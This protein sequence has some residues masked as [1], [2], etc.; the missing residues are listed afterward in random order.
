[1]KTE[2]CL[3]EDD[4]SMGESLVERMQLEGYDVTLF[5]TGTAAL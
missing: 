4:P 1:M 2:V 3:I 5:S